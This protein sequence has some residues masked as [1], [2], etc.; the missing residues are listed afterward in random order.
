[1]DGGTDGL[2]PLCSTLEF[3]IQRSCAGECGVVLCLELDGSRH[4]QVGRMEVDKSVGVANGRRKGEPRK[5]GDGHTQ[6]KE[7]HSGRR[8]QP[9]RGLMPI[10]ND[11]V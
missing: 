9:T 8:I 10:K 6:R 5:M 7:Q 11:S 1:M 2:E 4:P 3:R